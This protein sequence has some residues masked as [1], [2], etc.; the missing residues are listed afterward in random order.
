MGANAFFVHAQTSIKTGCHVLVIPT[1]S[2]D[3]HVLIRNFNNTLYHIRHRRFIDEIVSQTVLVLRV[4]VSV[5]EVFS[6][7]TFACVIFF[8]NVRR[9]ADK[10]ILIY[11]AD[12]SRSSSFILS[13]GKTDY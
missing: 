13:F 2:V 4:A 9:F 3:S 10:R 6:R 12:D 7:A 11:S 1:N 5:L 8:R